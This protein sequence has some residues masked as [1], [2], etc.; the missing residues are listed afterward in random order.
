MS[1]NTI[2]SKGSTRVNEDAAYDK[3]K[4]YDTGASADSSKKSISYDKGLDKKKHDMVDI[5]IGVFFDGTKNNMMNTDATTNKMF[6]PS[7]TKKTYDMVSQKLRDD[8]RE[9][10]LSRIK[11]DSSYGNDYTNVARMY[12]YYEPKPQIGGKLYVAGIGTSEGT[13]EGKS[14]GIQD[15]QDGYAFGSGPTGIVKRVEKACKDVVDIIDPLVEKHPRRKDKKK[16]I[17][18]ILVFDVFGFSRGAAAARHF[19]HE[20]HKAEPSFGKLGEALREKNIELRFLVIRFLGIYDTVSSFEDFGEEVNRNKSNAPDPVYGNIANSTVSK[21]ISSVVTKP[22]TKLMTKTNP[23]FNNDIEDLKIDNI[24]MVKKMVHFTAGDEHRKYFALTTAKSH[25]NGKADELQ[26]VE[27]MLPGAHSDIGGSYVDNMEENAMISRSIDINP[28][29]L[30]SSFPYIVDLNDIE[31]SSK[32]KQSLINE[33]EQLIRDGWYRYDNEKKQIEIIDDGL[34]NKGRQRYKLIG[35][36]LISNRYSFIPLHFMVELARKSGVEECF[37][38]EA[39]LKQEYSIAGHSILSQIEGELRKVVFEDYPAFIFENLVNQALTKER[40]NKNT[41]LYKTLRN[42]YLH[43][44]AIL[45][46]G[47]TPRTI[48]YKGRFNADGKR[49]REVFKSSPSLGKPGG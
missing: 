39:G 1:N 21:V 11:E 49:E 42:E 2:Q 32:N 3:K 9:L 41:E 48:D 22:V 46:V 33:K 13:K 19:I 6:N 28:L 18:D 14:D 38:N 16:K 35:K 31:T 25:N 12:K 47:K 30:S 4:I 8:L 45:E 43:W 37:K 29:T 34:I 27:K 7:F 10:H 44:S 26:F 23:N 20:I 24:G 17:I 36:R 40:G 15:D 5:E